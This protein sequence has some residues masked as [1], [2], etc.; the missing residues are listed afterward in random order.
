MTVSSILAP[1]VPPPCRRAS[2]LAWALGGT[3]LVL[4]TVAHLVFWYAP[5]ARAVRP[6]P[7]DLPAAVLAGSPQP[8]RL[9]LAYPHQNLAA[10]RAGTLDQLAG[11]LGPSLPAFG[12]FRLPPSRELAVAS[13]PGG[14]V[15]V[16]RVY[17]GLARVAR[18]A[19]RLAAN[20]WLGGGSVGIDGREGAVEWRGSLW[21]ARWGDGALPEAAFAPEAL[22][23]G[24]RPRAVL[25]WLDPEALGL[26]VPARTGLWALEAS[27]GALLLERLASGGEVA[28]AAVGRVA[29][30][31]DPGDRPEELALLAWRQRAAGREAVLL[32]DQAQD[33]GV[34]RLPSAALAESATA[35]R[36]FSLPAEELYE[37]LGA[38]L[39]RAAHG[40]WSIVGTDRRSVEL[41]RRL[42]PSARSGEAAPAGDRWEIGLRPAAVHRLARAVDE[43]F[44]ALPVGS[45]RTR[46][47]WRRY[48]EWSGALRGHSWV[49]LTVEP[50]RILVTAEPARPASRR[51]ASD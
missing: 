13:G 44:Q 23:A 51:P 38:K 33:P 2:R 43:A 22:P 24:E 21:T 18:A 29:L 9:W 48:R 10:G 49:A 11:I 8:M 20:P 3:V 39:R 45:R 47:R 16:A 50:D 6:D 26:D 30:A 31:P 7:R 14:G 28:P 1:A 34:L 40:E 19:G 42:L 41:A 5:R 46:E 12:P 25:A 17:P 32:L 15:A 4:A 36:R 27:D 37:A 35:D